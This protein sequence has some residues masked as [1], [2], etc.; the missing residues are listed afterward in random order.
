MVSAA[1]IR[2]G[3]PLEMPSPPKR[4]PTLDEEV[5]MSVL[6]LLHAADGTIA[7]ADLARAFVLRSH[8]DL[9][10]DLAPT[11]LPQVHEWAARVSVRPLPP[12][13]LVAILR[14]LEER[15]A[16]AFSIDDAS[17]SVVT[18]GPATTPKE[19]IHAWFTYEANLALLVLRTVS[20]QRLRSIHKRLAGEDRSLVEL[21]S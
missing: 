5:A 21:A 13:K 1:K 17:Q 16:L 15:G 8:P 11:S 18:I 10:R 6:A 2:Q 12:G 4:P 7:R 19:K 3:H 20:Q 14:L 9:L